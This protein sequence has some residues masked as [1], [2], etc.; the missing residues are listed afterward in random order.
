[1]GFLDAFNLF[2]H[3]RN[4]RVVAYGA[5]SAGR[6]RVA[7]IGVKQP[8]GMGALKVS[9]DA[10]RAQ[11]SFVEWKV[12]PRFESDD[13]VVFHKELD[14]ALLT[15]EAAMGVDRLVRHDARIQ[16]HARRSR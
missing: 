8:I 4:G 2:G 12:I 5:E 15:A 7:L 13:L 11:L 16:S 1:V 10:F 3:P 14:A 6:L 9:L